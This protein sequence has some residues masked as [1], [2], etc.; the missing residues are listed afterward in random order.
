M[1][2]DQIIDRAL[3]KDKTSLDIE[4]TVSAGYVIHDITT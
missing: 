3:F 2:V 1:N 4:G